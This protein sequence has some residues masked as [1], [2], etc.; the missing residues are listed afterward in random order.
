MTVVIWCGPQ[1]TANITLVQRI[2]PDRPGTEVEGPEELF[3]YSFNGDVSLLL[4]DDDDDDDDDVMM[5]VMVIVMM[6]RMVIRLMIEVEGP[7]EL[8]A[9]S[10]NG[11]VSPDHHE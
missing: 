9:Y 10:F 7:E 2:F 11:Y 4:D 5:M 6:I 3:A 1:V 8:F